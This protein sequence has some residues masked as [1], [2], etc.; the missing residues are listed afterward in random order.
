[1]LSADRCLYVC[2]SGRVAGL[3]LGTGLDR[4]PSK[5][6]A[7]KD[8]RFRAEQVGEGAGQPWS[9]VVTVMC[10]VSKGLGYTDCQP[11]RCRL[12]GSEL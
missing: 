8:R 7:D 4:P 9:V 2:V 6:S 3:G 10:C 12:E 5:N 1:M 11:A